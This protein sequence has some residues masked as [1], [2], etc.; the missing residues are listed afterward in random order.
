MSDKIQKQENAFREIGVSG[1]EEFAGRVYED[2]LRILQ[3]AN[4]SRIYYQMSEND[5]VIGALM[6]AIKGLL[7][8]VNWKFVSASDSDEDVANAE[9]LE[10]C[11]DDMESGFGDYILEMASF[12]NYGFSVT[13]L[14]YKKRNG[15][16][17]EEL[18]SSKYND[19]KFGWKRLPSRSQ[20]SILEGYWDIDEETQ[21]IKGV[22]QYPVTGGQFYI[23]AERFIHLRTSLA[24]MNPQG[25]SILR[26][27]YRPWYFKSRIENYEAIGVERDLAGIPVA[28]V[29]ATWFDPNS[30]FKKQFEAVQRIVT[31]IKRDEQEGLVM[32]NL[33][34][35][36]GNRLITLELMASGGKRQYQTGEIIG[37]KND[38]I[39]MTAL[40]DFIKLGQNS[41]GSHALAFSKTE[42]FTQSIKGWVSVIEDGFNRQAIP[43]LLRLNGFNG[44]MPTL[45]GEG[46]DKVDG[47]IFLHN[48]KAV[49][50]AGYG[51]I[52][53]EQVEDKIR[54]MLDLPD[55]DKGEKGGNKFNP[56]GQIEEGNMDIKVEPIV[57]N[58]E[59]VEEEEV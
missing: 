41:V 42:I 29:P 19:G 6:F 4:G 24:K 5:P 53:D 1:L 17:R 49:A 36:Q 32:P 2:P 25:R 51:Y 55:S 39:L 22:W 30:E 56:R 59:V 33:I 3:G 54:N 43:R 58:E 23:P 7:R 26:N 11:K 34:D 18:F 21:T 12:L 40:A 46:L 45:Q 48:L 9:F 57:V 31:T 44:E 14:S 15:Y 13:E 47:S 8:Q 52:L 28:Y 50:D 16:K 27:A 20:T 35:E 38:E 10:Q 37:R